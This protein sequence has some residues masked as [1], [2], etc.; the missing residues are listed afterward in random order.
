[1]LS[2][3]WRGVRRFF[4]FDQVPVAKAKAKGTAVPSD[5]EL[6]AAAAS[7][8]PEWWIPKDRKAKE[9]VQLEARRK[10]LIEKLEEGKARQAAAGVNV[11]TP[12]TTTRSINVAAMTEV[13]AAAEPADAEPVAAR[14]DE[15]M[16]VDLDQF[17]SI[18]EVAAML[19][20]RRRARTEEERRIESVEI[21]QALMMTDE[22]YALAR[23]WMLDHRTMHP[24]PRTE[25]YGQYWVHFARTSIGDT[26]SIGC[27]T[28]GRSKILTD[29]S[30]LGEP[31]AQEGS[32]G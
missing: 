20:E 21:P 13:H 17:T 1:M 7:L 19:E 15:M 9:A 3:F 6:E 26:A 18:D 5:A 14:D 28:C 11:D 31:A 32:A 30:Q 16:D 22:E 2:S 23:D 27:V 8:A 10:A 12:A 4:G 29:H 25:I 24:L